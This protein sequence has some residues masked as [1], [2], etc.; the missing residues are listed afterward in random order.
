MCEAC[1]QSGANGIAH[2]DHYNR[3]CL[4]RCLCSL[5]SGR[6]ICNDDAHWDAG[7]F[8]CSFCKSGGLGFIGSKFI[9]N[10]LTFAIT[11]VRMASRKGGQYGALP[12][13]PTKMAAVPREPPAAIPAPRH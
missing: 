1:N 6:A 9:L 7:E 11:E 13:R 8:L 3:D 12:I 2:L 10:V 5:A 4:G